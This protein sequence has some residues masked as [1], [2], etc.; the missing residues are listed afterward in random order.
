[1]KCAIPDCEGRPLPCFETA[2]CL[3]H[4]AESSFLLAEVDRL[5][6]ERDRALVLT[7]VLNA[8]LTGA[9]GD[10]KRTMADRDEARAQVALLRKTLKK[11]QSA[12]DRLM[13]DTDSFDDKD[14]S[15]V[16]MHC[17]ALAL[18]ATEPKP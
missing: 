1:M 11:A 3:A 4:G 18:T 14:P 17:I 15:L 5:K 16:V 13:G 12:L 6:A 10:Y 9:S 2:L 8:Q 7:G